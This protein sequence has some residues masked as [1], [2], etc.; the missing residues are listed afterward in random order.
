MPGINVSFSLD[1]QVQWKSSTISTAQRC[2]AVA[3]AEI[4]E[5]ARLLNCTQCLPSELSRSIRAPRDKSFDMIVAARNRSQRRRHLSSW[6]RLAILFFE[7]VP[8]GPF[9]FRNQPGID[10]NSSRSDNDPT[11]PTEVTLLP[12]EEGLIHLCR[13]WRQWFCHLPIPGRNETRID[14]FH[15]A[16]MPVKPSGA[17]GSRG[18]RFWSR[19]ER[20]T[21]CKSPWR[22]TQTPTRGRNHSEIRNERH[23]KT[24]PRREALTP[25]FART[26]IKISCAAITFPKKLPLLPFASF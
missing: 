11:P 24:L 15:G 25:S 10:K 1:E 16:P 21:K 17:A 26:P 18:G 6:R 8:R 5:P 23:R 9:H 14:L 2:I 4:Q 22:T 13:L 19:H 20:H 12:S 3:W 7:S